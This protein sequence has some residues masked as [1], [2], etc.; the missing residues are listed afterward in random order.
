MF[1]GYRGTQNYVDLEMARVECYCGGV[2][3]AMP[4]NIHEAR[5]FR[6]PSCNSTFF[7]II[8]WEEDEKFIDYVRSQSI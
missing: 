7:Q 5:S 6:C 3:W 1:Q 8:N 4:N 2:Q